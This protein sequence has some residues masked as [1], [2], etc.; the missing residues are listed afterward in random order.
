MLKKLFAFLVITTFLS[1]LVIKT[2]S[3]ETTFQPDKFPYQKMQV[4]VMPEFDYPTNWPKNTPSLLVGIYGTFTNKSGQDYNGQ[5]E[6]PVPVN[7]KNFQ[8]NLVAE[9]PDINKPE[10]QRPFTVDKEKGTITWTPGTPIKKNATYNY[11]IE[12]Y[13][14]TISVSNQKSFTY[15]LTNNADIAQLNVIYYAPMNAKNIQMEPKAQGTD[16][17]DYGENLYYYQYQ[18]VKKGTTLK[19]SF[20]YT[21]TNNDSTMS[22]M[23]KQQP[24]NDTTHSGV[25][26]N[27][28]STTTTSSRPIISTGGAIVIAIAI[29]IFGVFVFLGL[30]GGIRRPTKPTSTKNTQ[31]KNHD[32]T[33]KPAKKKE[34]K[35]ANAEEKKE[36][37]KKL[38]DGKIDQETY[39]EEM[40][41]LI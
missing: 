32:K 24:P 40:K 35:L 37:R 13:V 14:N 28:T 3:A 6:I 31:N 10:V 36:L 15:D 12:Y 23:Q 16:K 4:Q 34:N 26:N 17:S 29:I 5:I 2:A 39:E 38:L 41:K 27:N 8:A 21:K 18:N 30:K 7:A 1:S 25:K 22:V 11:V 33:Q 20:K 19:Y 9:F